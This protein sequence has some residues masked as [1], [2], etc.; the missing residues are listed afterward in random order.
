MITIHVELRSRFA[1]ELGQDR[2]AL[3]FDGEDVSVEAIMEKLFAEKPGSVAVK[4]RLPQAMFVSDNRVLR[5]ESRLRDG[6]ILKVFP[7]IFG[8]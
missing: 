7:H 4:D 1:E 2:F 5:A 3:D 8:G 6:D